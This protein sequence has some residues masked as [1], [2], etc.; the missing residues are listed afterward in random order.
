MDLTSGIFT[1]PRPGIYFFSFSGLASFPVSSG[2]R[3]SLGVG[4]YLNGDKIGIGDVSE[5]NT[6]VYQSSP[7]TLQ[8]TLK[9]KKGDQV[10][11]EIVY[12]STG[13]YLADIIYNHY[14]HFTGFMLEEEIVALL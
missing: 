12:Q 14:T 9:L 10:W 1:A 2:S 8:S 13:T 6:V 3:V 5:G 7:L 4:L 11:M